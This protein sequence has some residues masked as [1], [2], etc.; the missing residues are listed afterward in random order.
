MKIKCKHCLPAEGIEIPDFEESEKYTLNKKAELSP[1]NLIKYIMTHYSMS[2]RDAKYIALHV[3]TIY[4][5]CNRC[6][7]DNLNGEYITCPKCEA[8]NFNWQNLSP[9]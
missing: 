9:A 7:F 6:N 1:I 4:G 5:H 8:L 2:H 3:N